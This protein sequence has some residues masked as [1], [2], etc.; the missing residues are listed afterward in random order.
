MS[1]V[2]NLKGAAM[3]HDDGRKGVIISDEHCGLFNALTIEV[4]QGTQPPVKLRLNAWG[5]DSGE[6]GWKWE[7]SPIHYPGEFAYLLDIDNQ[8]QKA[9]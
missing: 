7:F 8:E 9:S 4:E 5:K 3:L 1:D 2:K 6:Q